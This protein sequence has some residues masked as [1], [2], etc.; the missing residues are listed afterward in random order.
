MNTGFTTCL[1]PAKINLFLHITGRR[2]D[3]YHTLQTAFRMLDHGDLLHFRVRDDGLILRITDVPEVPADQDLIVRAARML[4]MRT[5]CTLGAD[6]A[7]DKRLP[8]GGGLG[9]GSSDAATTLLALNRLWG[10]GVRRDT[11]QAWALELGADVPFFI[12]GRTALA[13][14]VGEALQALDLPSASY[15]VVEPPVSVP[16]AEIFR[17]QGLTRDSEAVIIS[18]FPAAEVLRRIES[19]ARNDMQPVACRLYPAVQRAVDVLASYSTAYGAARMSGSGAC[20]FLPVRGEPAGLVE[21]LKVVFG[22]SW[23]VWS[24]PA[25]DVHPL[26]DWVEG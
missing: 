1:A 16:T 6:I 23:R 8:M 21:E 10:L 25:L 9:G 19:E 2:A 13:E 18:G 5:N 4:Q 12:F 17:D 11:L 15:V 3:G 7:I 22:E 26:H 20:V 24:A 14:G